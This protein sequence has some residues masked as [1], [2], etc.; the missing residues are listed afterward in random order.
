MARVEKDH[1][2]HLVSTPCCV[3]G[4]QPQDQAAQS[5][6]NGVRFIRQECLQPE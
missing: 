2:D 3:Q 1:N 5:Q 6:E 4:L